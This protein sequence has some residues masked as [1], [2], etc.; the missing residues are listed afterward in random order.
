MGLTQFFYSLVTKP[1]M[2]QLSQLSRRFTVDFF[3]FANGRFKDK[4]F[5]FEILCNFCE[6]FKP[7][8]S[9][10][11]YHVT[12]ISREVVKGGVRVVSVRP[13]RPS[14]LGRPGARF[15]QF[16]EPLKLRNL[17][18]HNSEPKII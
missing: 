16:S 5:W 2:S 8:T 1:F 7:D 15:S 4:M 11:V 10:S 13:A 12:Y 9:T 6:F 3:T 17:I 18:I 14:K